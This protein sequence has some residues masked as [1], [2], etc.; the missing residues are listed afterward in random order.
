MKKSYE[1]YKKGA[2]AWYWHWYNIVRNK[3]IGAEV[4]EMIGLCLIIGLAVFLLAA[5]VLA[6]CSVPFAMLGW[7]GLVVTNFFMP[8][9]I[10]YFKA[11]M[12]GIVMSFIAKAMLPR[13]I[14]VSPK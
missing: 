13:R 6:V 1:E 2:Q 5:I 9:A 12:A 3:F 11:T 7:A 8:V 10:T 14:R 4:L